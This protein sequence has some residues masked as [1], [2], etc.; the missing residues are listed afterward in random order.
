M[1][2]LLIVPVV[3]LGMLFTSNVNAQVDGDKQAPTEEGTQEEYAKIDNAELPAAVT[4]AVERD[5]K[6]STV[7]E[8]Y[9]GKDKSY[10]L[11]LVNEAG[12]KGMVYVDATG[13]WITPSK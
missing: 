5:F 3:A 10:K 13:K 8:A 7:A 6:G 11:V 12:D 1:K 4:A 9:L 2:K